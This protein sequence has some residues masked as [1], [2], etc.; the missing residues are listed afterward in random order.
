MKTLVARPVLEAIVSFIVTTVLLACGLLQWLRLRVGSMLAIMYLDGSP[1]G[2]L[3]QNRFIFPDSFICVEYGHDALFYR[4]GY[5]GVLVS[6][7]ESL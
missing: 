3:L 4:R 5:S 6:T 7:L 1:T 2:I